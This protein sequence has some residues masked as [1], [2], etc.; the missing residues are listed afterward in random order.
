MISPLLNVELNQYLDYDLRKE[1]E[2]SRIREL[3]S[4]RSEHLV[5]RFARELVW[6]WKL[7]HYTYREYDQPEG[8]AM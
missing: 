8:A 6:R 2:R 7:G 3:A 4:E 1:R 5:A